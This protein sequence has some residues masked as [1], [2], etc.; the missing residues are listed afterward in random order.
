MGTRRCLAGK[1][2]TA[3]RKKIAKAAAKARWAQ[4][5]ERMLNDQAITAALAADGSGAAS[6]SK[7]KSKSL[8]SITPL[9]LALIMFSHGIVQST[10]M[11][12][13]TFSTLFI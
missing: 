12:I 1:L 4:E 9:T 10:T 8:T 2:T 6:Y 3:Q 5:E 7:I 11:Y 13:L